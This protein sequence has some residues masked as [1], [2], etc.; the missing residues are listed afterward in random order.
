MKE[1]R[2]SC[3]D[4][5]VDECI[6]Q[7]IETSIEG[8]CS[9]NELK[10]RLGISSK[11]MTKHLN[12]LEDKTRNNIIVRD[13]VETPW[14]AGNKRY[15]RLTQDTRTKRKYYGSFRLDYKSVK[16]LCKDKKEKLEKDI[17][18]FR[19]TKLVLFLLFAL[20]YGYMGYKNSSKGVVIRKDYQEGNSTFPTTSR[21]V[22]ATEE[23]GFS[24]ND[25]DR[26]DYHLSTLQTSMRANRFER[27][28][29]EELMNEIVKY[30]EIELTPFLY[31][32]KIRYKIVDGILNEFLIYCC[33]IIT[34]LV[35]VMRAYFFLFNKQG[36]PDER[37]WFYDILGD[38]TANAFFQQIEE[39]QAE[40]KTI[41]NL[42]IEFYQ[43]DKQ[44]PNDEENKKLVGLIIQNCEKLDKDFFTKKKLEK[45]LLSKPKE[46][47]NSLIS[48][49]IMD[50]ESIN[51]REEK[52]EDL[53]VK[54][55]FIFD[56]I[57]DIVN[58][59]FSRKWFKIKLFF[60]S[61]EERNNNNP[62]INQ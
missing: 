39:N 41:K 37:K 50:S 27:K 33:N 3:Y 42:Y 18:K 56:E 57:R 19:R 44:F 4:P 58:P 8:K 47:N 48:Q 32:E 5:D 60:Q 55:P 62:I 14:S 45:S 53:K 46:N 21:T 23:P 52:F 35:Q 7:T 15:I 30:K 36:E 61:Y 24:P 38:E 59:P 31:K 17:Q 51:Q 10:K 13:K 26:M 6:I 40:K 16:G 12:I 43:Y 25:L 28:K 29:T 9:F 2:K 34:T 20:A 11:T 49:L 54:Y 1:T 22:S